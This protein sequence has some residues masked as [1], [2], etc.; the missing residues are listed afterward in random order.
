MNRFHITALATA[1][2]ACTG[3]ATMNPETGAATTQRAAMT[4]WSAEGLQPVKV[5]DLDLVYTR[6]DANL[7]QYNKVLVRPVLVSFQRNWERDLYTY[8]RMRPR[9]QDV[10]RLRNDMSQVVHEQVVRE[11]GKG[12]YRVVDAPG[13]G[14]LAIEVHVA[15][16]YLNAPD[17][18]MVS[19]VRSYTLSFGDM[20]LIA[21]IRDSRTGE[22]V[23]RVLDRSLGRDTLMLHR[24]TR[25][26]NAFEVGV[27]SNIW[28]RAVR[29]QLDQAKA[30]ASR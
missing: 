16:L 22:S 23:M 8:A 10:E 28:A 2:L 6:P 29:R 26:E 5:S 19:I 27:A 30:I 11:L 15:D 18:P 24:T 14:V 4:Q 12:G 21:D 9:P 17:L 3:M 1:L 13:E 7:S 25:V 20:T